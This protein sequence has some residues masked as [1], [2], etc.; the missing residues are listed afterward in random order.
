[1]SFF[2]VNATFK[3]WG[4]YK[5]TLSFEERG[6]V[7]WFRIRLWI[8]YLIYNSRS[9]WLIA[10]ST[11]FFLFFSEETNQGSQITRALEKLNRVSHNTLNHQM[12]AIYTFTRAKAFF[13]CVTQ[14]FAQEKNACRW[15]N[16]HATDVTHPINHSCWPSF[17]GPSNQYQCT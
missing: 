1:M 9:F 7:E 3:L 4:S 11:L 17:L 15:Q 8:L 5:I 14:S 16:C 13:D 6:L 2:T 12:K 10:L